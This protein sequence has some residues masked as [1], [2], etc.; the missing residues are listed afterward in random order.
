LGVLQSRT[1]TNG[2]DVDWASLR[3]EQA[4]AYTIL[5]RGEKTRDLDTYLK[6]YDE[7]ENFIAE[8]DDGAEGY[9]ARIRAKLKPGTYSIRVHVL[10]SGPFDEGYT[11]LVE[12]E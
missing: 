6:L 9:S 2:D 11:L 8:D 12:A 5:A 4:G 10:D 7:G 3:I 1:F